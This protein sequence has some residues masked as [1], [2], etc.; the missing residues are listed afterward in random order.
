MEVSNQH[1]DRN[2][3]SMYDAFCD[4]EAAMRIIITGGTGLIGR[5]LS[6][7]LVRAGYEVVVLSRNPARRTGM[8]E[9]VTVTRWDGQTGRG[10]AELANGAAAIVNLA[11]ESL[12]GKSLLA[13]RWTPKRTREI[14]GSRVQAGS[15]VIE[16]VRNAAQKPQLVVQASGVG[17]YGPRGSE[18]IT[19]KDSAGNDFMYEIC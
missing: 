14:L 18:R 6:D 9:G 8:P 16:A 15:A 12:A 13:M 11:G 3:K 5:Y 7:E 1:V 17:Y 4:K 10:W 19:E 2:S